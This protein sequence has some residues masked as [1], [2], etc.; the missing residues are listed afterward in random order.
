MAVLQGW[1]YTAD[2]VTEIEER[3]LTMAS[4][5]DHDDDC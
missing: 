5:F 2:D 4:A 3:L 1:G